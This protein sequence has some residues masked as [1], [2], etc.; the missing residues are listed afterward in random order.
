VRL[1]A[2]QVSAVLNEREVAEA[3]ARDLAA[4]K[5]DESRPSCHGITVLLYSAPR[6]F[7]LVFQALNFKP[8]NFSF[9]KLQCF[10]FL[11]LLMIDR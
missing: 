8:Y 3:G 10:S 11:T 2:G 5:V 7:C 9:G 1:L 6:H 4:R